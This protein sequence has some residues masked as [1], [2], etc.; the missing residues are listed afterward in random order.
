MN[1][2]EYFLW[3][4]I[5]A[6]VFSLVTGLIIFFAKKGTRYHVRMGQVYY[7]AMTI[8][9][10]TSV[11]VSV[12]KNN[13][14]LLL[15]GFFSFYLVQS[16]IRYSRV[17][18]VKDIHLKDVVLS[19]LYAICFIFM[20]VLGFIVWFKGSNVLGIVLLVFGSIG[21][22]LSRLDFVFFILKRERSG[23]ND[24]MKDHIGRMTGSYIAAV[25]AFAVNNVHFMPPLMI[26]LLPTCL[27][28]GVI[29]YYNRK[30]KL[31]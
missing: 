4:H 30:L 1:F 2:V 7:L 21:L 11:Y 22:S 31:N 26:W 18:F 16:G 25:T 8:V 20:V 10:V 9:F 15:I 3:I 12:A 17:R 24:W 14:F 5:V 28:F 27:G 23:K 29:I 13:I 19:L 6:G